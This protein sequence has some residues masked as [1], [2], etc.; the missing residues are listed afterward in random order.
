MAD[1]MANLSRGIRNCKLNDTV[2]LLCRVARHTALDVSAIPCEV[3][4]GSMAL[5]AR[6]LLTL[7]CGHDPQSK[8]LVLENARA[9]RNDGMVQISRLMVRGQLHPN[10]AA[11]APTLAAG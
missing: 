7:H 3:A 2:A 6:P 11:P 9:Q 4:E 1:C 8:V 10:S 5:G